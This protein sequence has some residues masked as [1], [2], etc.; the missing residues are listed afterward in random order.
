[1]V[2]PKRVLSMGKIELLYI[3]KV[4]KKNDFCE[5]ELLEIEMFDHLTVCND[6]C[7]IEL[8]VIKSNT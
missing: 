6:G 5:V 7:L 2:A 8:L 4:R 1:M 3:K